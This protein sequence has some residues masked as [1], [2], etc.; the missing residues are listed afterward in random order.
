MPG[1][2]DS[3][4]RRNDE[5]GVRTEVHPWIPAFAGMT[6]EGFAPRF[7]LDSGLRRKEV[8]RG[9]RRK[10]RLHRVIPDD[11]QRRCGIQSC[12]NA[13]C[14]ATWIPAFAGK[15]TEL[16]APRFTPGFRPSPERRGSCSH[17]GSP[18]IPA[19]AGKARELFAPRF[20]LDSGLRRND[21]GG[22][23]ASHRPVGKLAPEHTALLIQV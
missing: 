19:S 9:Y 16:F 17:R 22:A 21:D 2:L 5:G 18:W 6:T 3:G 14:R 15:T 8:E 23:R 12:A 11:A 20:T 7:T 10:D 1:T 13:Q 4:L